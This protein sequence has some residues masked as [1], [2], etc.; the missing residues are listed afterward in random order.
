MIETIEWISF[1]EFSLNKLHQILLDF[2]WLRDLRNCGVQQHK[3]LLNQ[4]RGEK[5]PNNVKKIT[6]SESFWLRV[7]TKTQ[8]EKD[9]KRKVAM[10]SLNWF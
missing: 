2:V 7:D 3:Y 10:S 9:I 4:S 1:D 5:S 6:F 8:R